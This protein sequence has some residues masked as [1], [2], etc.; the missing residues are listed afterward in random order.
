[1]ITIKLNFLNLHRYILFPR[2]ICKAKHAESTLRH[3]HTIDNN[4][5]SNKD[6]IAL[7]LEESPR[8][9]L[10]FTSK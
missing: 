4:K 9:A 2:I 10:V 3:T 8:A 1:M 7:L 5:I 6:E